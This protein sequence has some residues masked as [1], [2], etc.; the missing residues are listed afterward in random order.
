[1]DFRGS[2][3]FLEMGTQEAGS[4]LCQPYTMTPVASKLDIV[5]KSY[6]SSPVWVISS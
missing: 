3:I 2:E 1:M 6:M 5:A 4:K